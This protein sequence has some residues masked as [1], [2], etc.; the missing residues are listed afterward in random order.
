MSGGCKFLLSQS[1]QAKKG[2][3]ISFSLSEKLLQD[4]LAKKAQRHISVVLV[5]LVVWL[6]QPAI[7]A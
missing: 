6:Y 5:N 2:H 7:V 3:E 4:S 1:E